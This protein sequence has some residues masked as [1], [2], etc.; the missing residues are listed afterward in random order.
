[1]AGSSP[2]SRQALACAALM[3]LLCLHSASADDRDSAFIGY[4]EKKKD[5]LGELLGTGVLA[6]DHA[7]LWL[8]QAVHKN[9]PYAPS[10]R[11]DDSPP[12][13]RPILQATAGTRTPAA[14]SA[15]GQATVCVTPPS[16][17]CADCPAACACAT[18]RPRR[19]RRWAPCRPPAAGASWPPRCSCRSQGVALLRWRHALALMRRSGRAVSPRIGTSL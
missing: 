18:R 1:M 12:A 3:L 14:R 7:R 9:I 11:G 6:P 16:S 17:S 19:R 15:P 8:A 13:A 5:K 2:L 10:P 4:S